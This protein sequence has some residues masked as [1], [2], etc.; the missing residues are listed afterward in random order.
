MSTRTSDRPV[1]DD[2]WTR[3]GWVFGGIW[4]FFWGFPLASIW[5][6]DRSL[7]F[8]LGT[9]ALIVLYMVVYV[10]TVRTAIARVSCHDYARAAR[11][12]LVGMAILIAIV[13]VLSFFIATGALTGMPFIVGM[14]V[15][16]LPWRRV[17]T[18]SLG[19]LAIGMAVSWWLWG[20]WPAGMFWGISVL[21]LGMSAI[22]RYT[23]E[24]QESN[25]EATSR[26]ELVE[27]RERVARDVHDVLGHS[28]TVVA[29]KAELAKRLVDVDPERAKAELAEVQD[30][31]RQALAEIRATVGGL[32]VA[33][34]QEEVDAARMALAGADIAAHLPQD[35]T[36]VDPRF[37]ITL[38]W[39]LRE[40]VTNVVRHSRAQNCTVELGAD[41]VRVID[42]GRGIGGR[43]EGNGLGGLRERVAQAGGTLNVSPGPDGLGTTVEVI[44]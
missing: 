6:S 37:R 26:L 5:G 13:V 14:G 3:W 7:T 44:L 18:I 1:V 16:V 33:R 2:P 43:K 39:V 29:M 41:T 20:L 24:R 42:D 31:S 27:E 9:T 15:F 17:W 28:L 11:F 35:V 30:L 19:L 12:G 25:R 8:Q 34:L 40:A 32:R 21:V 36:V 10:T 22:S 38:A 23:E 4:L